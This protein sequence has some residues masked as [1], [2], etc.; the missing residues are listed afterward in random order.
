MYLKNYREL[1]EN[2]SSSS[3]RMARRICLESLEAALVATEPRRL[4]MKKMKLDGDLI[5]GGERIRLSKFE[6]IVVVGGGKAAVAMAEVMENLLDGRISAG[7]VNVPDKLRVRSTGK[8][9]Y[10]RATH[11]LPSQE[12]V[13]GVTKMLDIIG[14]PSEDTLVICLIS[15]GGSALMPLPRESVTLSDK[16]GV[17]KL[18]LN[19]GATIRELNIVRKHLSGIKGGWLARKLYPCASVAIVISDVVGDGLDSIASG[20]LYPDQ[21]TFRDALA[22]LRKYGVQNKIPTNVALTLRKGLAHELPE[23]PKEGDRCFRRVRHIVVGSNADACGAAVRK[24]QTLRRRPL[25]LTCHLSGE[26]QHAG[27]VLGSIA[28]DGLGRVSPRQSFLSLVAGGETTVRVVGSGRGG[29]NQE[30]AL[31]ASISLEGAEEI[32]LGFIETD[33]LDG[34]T[35]AAGAIVDGSTLKRARSKGLDADEYLGRNDAYNFF[36]EIGDLVITGPTGTNVS[37]ISVAARSRA[38][39]R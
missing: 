4:M 1:V 24:L 13:E 35:D 37:D 3:D 31:G 26:A 7:L 29:R 5:I 34:P 15:G 12:G 23:T 30:A 9:A 32:A 20:P 22:V 11:P 18:L 25:Y 36:R 33:G 17:T 28:R 38:I 39:I 21:S 19:A 14:K 8:I 10:H 27:A 2:G 6:R 16:V